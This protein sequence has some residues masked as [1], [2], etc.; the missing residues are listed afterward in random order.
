MRAK[1]T[2]QLRKRWEYDIS[3]TDVV[4]KTEVIGNLSMKAIAIASD[5]FKGNL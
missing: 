4:M 1:P 2:Q 3:V 5:L